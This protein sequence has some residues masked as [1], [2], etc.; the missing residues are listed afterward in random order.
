MTYR[1]LE[2][3]TVG[4]GGNSSVQLSGGGTAGS[5]TLGHETTG[6]NAPRGDVVIAVGD[7]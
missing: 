6:D 3:L 4:A 2:E 7:S 5:D 1:C